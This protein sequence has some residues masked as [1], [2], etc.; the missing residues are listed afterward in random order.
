MGA[1]PKVDYQVTGVADDTQFGASA[2]PVPGKRVSYSTSIGYDGSLF[3]PDAVFGDA[4][5]VRALIEQEVRKV[6]AARQ[7]TGTLSG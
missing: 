2:S 5:A 4:P 3:I 1:G 6:S 7:I